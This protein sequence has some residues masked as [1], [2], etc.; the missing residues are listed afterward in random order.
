VVVL[1][2]STFVNGDKTANPE[3]KQGWQHIC[4]NSGSSVGY[5]NSISKLYGMS[6]KRLQFAWPALCRGQFQIRPEDHT[7]V[8]GGI[9][10]VS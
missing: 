9:P 2:S 8:I 7:N 6:A 1:N 4:V 5:V 3:L 10:Y